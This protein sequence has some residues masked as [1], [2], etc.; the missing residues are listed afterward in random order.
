M[1]R[2]ESLSEFLN[3]DLGNLK[4]FNLPLKTIKKL[5]G[6][7]DY[8]TGYAGR[9]SQIVQVPDPGNYKKLVAALKTRF[10]AGIISV[11]RVPTYLFSQIS[12]RK[13]KMYD[14]EA[15]R[16]DDKRDYEYDKKHRKEREE[17]NREDILK[18][19]E[20]R[21][22][23]LRK[24]KYGE[25]L[26]EGRRSWNR[27]DPEEVGEFSNK[28]LAD[29]I[30]KLIDDG[31][32][33]TLELIMPDEKRSEAQDSRRDSK[34]I[35]DP[36]YHPGRNGYSS[37]DYTSDS[38]SKRLKKYGAKKRLSLN[39]NLEEAKENLKNQIIK[40]FEKALDEVL[41]DVKD[42]RTYNLDTKSIGSELLRGVDLS[43]IKN[44]GNAYDAVKFDY[45]TDPSEAIKKLK[46][47][48]YLNESDHQY[49]DKI[50]A[51]N[52]DYFDSWWSDRYED[53]ESHK[54]NYNTGELIVY[55]DGGT[56]IDRIHI[57]DIEL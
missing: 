11:D 38:Q 55:S 41:R 31:K 35:T 47:L 15:L 36:L 16:N 56:E 33:V 42:G 2:F 44:L 9:E 39:K 29:K 6:T 50:G 8:Y 10:R 27:S 51:L 28:S 40:N 14:I 48:G 1:I 21:K 32:D 12:D 46:E 17:R 20:K 49:A 54:W 53:N 25:D 45:R 18:R 22:E 7:G 37:R 3:E 5:T 23:K 19:E 13:F 26:N 52:K 24:I 34:T 57:D 4:K 30:K 43:E